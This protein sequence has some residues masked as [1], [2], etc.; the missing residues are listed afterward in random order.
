MAYIVA[1]EP[2]PFRRHH[3]YVLGP[4]RFWL[5]AWI[6]A[7]LAM[8]KHPFGMAMIMP[9]DSLVTRGSEILWPDLDAIEQDAG[10]LP[11]EDQAWPDLPSTPQTKSSTSS[12]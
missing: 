12:P 4:F 11:R 10:L 9:D 1:I 7:K 8:W 3:S 5:R 6:A 2:S